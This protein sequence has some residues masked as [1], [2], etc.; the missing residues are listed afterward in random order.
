MLQL[1]ERQNPARLRV[2]LA[3]ATLATAFIF[4]RAAT[5]IHWVGHTVRLN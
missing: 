1:V 3:G 5:T 4:A 2:L